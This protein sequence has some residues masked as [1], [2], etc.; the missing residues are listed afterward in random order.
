MAKKRDLVAEI[1]SK[2]RRLG[3]GPQRYR[4]ASDRAFDLWWGMD[5][6]RALP[7]AS[8]RPKY[9]LLRYFSVG[10]VATLEGYYRL[11]LRDLIDLSPEFRERAARL[12]ET[13]LDAATVL[14]MSSER[15]SVAEVITHMLPMSST[16]DINRHMSVLTGEDYFGLVKKMPISVT[17]PLEEAFPAFIDTLNTAFSD[18]HIAC[19][20]VHPKLRLSFKRADTQWRAAMLLMQANENLMLELAGVRVRDRLSKPKVVAF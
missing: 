7:S 11:V 17:A 16:T 6:V 20:E 4:L 8:R 14:R 2:R 10:L 12:D 18:R 15:V 9:E 1:I 5:I 13:R 19:H 3:R